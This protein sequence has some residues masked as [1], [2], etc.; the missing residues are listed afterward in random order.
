MNYMEILFF[1]IL[2]LIFYSFFIYQGILYLFGMAVMLDNTN[3]SSDDL[4]TVTLIISAYNEEEVIRKKI[5]NSMNLK[6][7]RDKLE[8]M[9][10][11][12]NSEDRTDGIV[13]EYENKGVILKASSVRRGK[14]AGLN[15]A[16]SV[17]SG[18]IVVFT[19]A[20]SM[21]DENAIIEMVR[22]YS[23]PGVGAVTGSTNYIDQKNGE[24]VVTSSL[25]TRLERLTKRLES[26]IGSCVGADGAIFSIRKSLYIPLNDDDINDL[27]IPL[28]VV[29]Q[30]YRV[31]YSDNVLCTEEP[32]ISS[33]SA[34]SR[35]ARITNRTLRALFRRLYLLNFIKYPLFSFE[36][37]SHKYIRLSVP[38]LLIAILPI[39][40]SLLSESGFYIICFIGQL[41]IYALALV[42]FIQEK[43]HLGSGRFIIAYH[44]MMVQVS[45]LKGWLDFLSGENRVTWNPRN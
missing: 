7:P 10:V 42:G 24:M 30:G 33:G 18:D 23:N 31:I 36:M 13:K 17:A 9:V 12:D 27:V 26:K 5:E 15:D 4:P 2:I 8:I 40:F 29:W 39:N 43:Y 41:L 25:Y 16:V 21:F 11:S 14:T 38:F 45:I 34:F 22:L 32:S 35:Q 19:D 20:D 6:Y 44:F 1:L 37:L 28:N 3:N